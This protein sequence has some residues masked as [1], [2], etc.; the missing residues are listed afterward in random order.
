MTTGRL[1]KVE[2]TRVIRVTVE[3]DVSDWRGL[4]D[5]SEEEIIAYLSNDNEQETIE[6]AIDA[7]LDG[8]ALHADTKVTIVA[9]EWD[10]R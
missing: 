2:V 3:Y 9:R 5:M 1:S 8:S 4:Y 6:E 7:F 10:H